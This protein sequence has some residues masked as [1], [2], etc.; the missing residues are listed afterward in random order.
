MLPLS[1]KGGTDTGSEVA[2]ARSEEQAR[3]QAIRDGTSKIDSLFGGQFND[4]FYAGRAKSYENYALP[5]IA[6]QFGDASKELTFSLARRGALD[7][8]SR[9]SLATELEKRRAL[10]EQGVK[11]QARTFANTAKANVEGARADLVNTLNAT[12]DVDSAVRGATAR[13][14]VLSAVPGYSPI[15]SLFADFTAGLGQ[16][17]AAE[18]AFA[19]GAG[20]RPA[21]NTGLFGPRSGS[22]VNA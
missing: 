19:Y 10:Q 15:S 9:A 7:S 12:G 16:Q 2:L 18:R 13:A 14:Q 8:T 4:D 17:A 6:D 22:V 5:Q 3:Q 21:V 11:D 1:K 20:P